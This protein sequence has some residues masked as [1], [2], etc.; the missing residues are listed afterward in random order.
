L[1][2]QPTFVPLCLTAPEVD[3]S[4]GFLIGFGAIHSRSNP[5]A[6]PIACTLFAR[7]SYERNRPNGVAEVNLSP[8]V[9]QQLVDFIVTQVKGKLPEGLSQH[10]DGLLDRGSEA[11]GIMEKKP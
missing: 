6:S 8:E 2:G 7:S 11:V 5:T 3:L 10:V 1:A 9:S 4:P